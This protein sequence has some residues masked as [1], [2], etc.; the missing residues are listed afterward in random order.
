MQPDSFLL[1][2]N[3]VLETL[4]GLFPL[5]GDYTYDR[6][7]NGG[8]AFM[9]CNPC[10]FLRIWPRGDSARFHVEGHEPTDRHP[11][12]SSCLTANPDNPFVPW[13]IV[14]DPVVIT[15]DDTTEEKSEE[16]GS[17]TAEHGSDPDYH[18]TD[19]SGEEPESEGEADTSTDA[20]EPEHRG[21]LAATDGRDVD[22]AEPKD[23]GAAANAGI[24][25]APTVRLR[26]GEIPP[27]ADNSAAPSG[28]SKVSKTPAKAESSTAQDTKVRNTGAI[29]KAPVTKVKAG[30]QRGTSK[31]AT[32]RT[33]ANARSVDGAG[34]SSAS[35]LQAS[36]GRYIEHDALSLGDQRQLELE[37]TIKAS[38]LTASAEKAAAKSKRDTTERVDKVGS[39]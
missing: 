30:H 7:K 11:R 27:K 35:D 15:L 26:A 1:R 17:D 5:I 32:G 4:E 34:P 9:R 33:E 14:R 28:K 20:A 31:A 13:V 23:N 37:D 25:I 12:C 3:I 18:A 16:A 19:I 39:F 8:G 36:G 22:T 6:D 38:L 29:P 10:S 21:A 2:R 24:S